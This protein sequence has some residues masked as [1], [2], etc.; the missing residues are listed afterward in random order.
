MLLRG[1]FGLGGSFTQRAYPVAANTT[2]QKGDLLKLVASGGGDLKV[3]QAL[4]AASSGAVTISGG[5]QALIGVALEAITTNASSIETATGKTQIN[6]AILDPNLE[7]G[8]RFIGATV[9]VPTVVGTASELQDLTL[10]QTYRLA[11]Y[12]STQGDSF[13]VLCAETSNGELV[14]VEPYTGSAAADSF[15]VAW[16]RLAI[17]ETIQQG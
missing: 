17:S 5:N 16:T 4:A 12:T 13:Y 10:G 9:S 14:Y 2:I 15:G 3:T 8:V 7:I 6:V 1:R 11:R